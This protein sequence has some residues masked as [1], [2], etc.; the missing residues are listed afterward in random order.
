MPRLA[1]TTSVGITL[2]KYLAGTSLALALL[3]GTGVILHFAGYA[4]E[5]TAMIDQLGSS[6]RV[7][8][9]LALLTLCYGGICIFWGA[10]APETA[11]DDRGVLPGSCRGWRRRCR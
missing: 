11:A 3:L 8:G 1:C 10:V 9:G 7:L 4:T 5:P 2:G 6:M